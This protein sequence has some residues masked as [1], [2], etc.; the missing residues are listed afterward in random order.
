MAV[1][2]LMYHPTVQARVGQVLAPAITVEHPA[3]DPTAFYYFATP[4]LLSATGTV[5]EGL[6]QGNRAVTGMPI[7]GGAAIQYTLTDLVILA[8]GTYY[9]R[10]DLYGMSTGGANLVAQTN[11]ALVTVSN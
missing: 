1:T 11:P 8:P 6:L 9:L 2:Q 3:M 4:V 5:V 10:L 7:N